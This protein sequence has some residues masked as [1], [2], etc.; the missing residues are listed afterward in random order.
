MSDNTQYSA[1]ATGV[2]KLEMFANNAWGFGQTIKRDL[3]EFV[4]TYP[5]FS[6]N[7]A[8]FFAFIAVFAL[9]LKLEV[10]EKFVPGGR[11]SRVHRLA[12]GVASFGMAVGGA[13]LA[14]DG[15]LNTYGVN[16]SPNGNGQV[17]RVDRDLQKRIPD[18]LPAASSVSRQPEPVNPNRN[19]R[20]IRLD[21]YSP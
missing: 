11:D 14:H 8:G 15:T 6:A 2:E 7:A 16:A 17:I 19:D 18:E 21:P 5:D 9:S 20:V 1:S 13:V 12:V 4:T 3:G 10:A